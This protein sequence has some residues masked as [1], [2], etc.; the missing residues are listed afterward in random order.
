MMEL[1]RRAGNFVRRLHR[2]V[3]LIASTQGRLKKP[4]FATVLMAHT[5]QSQLVRG[6][7]IRG[8]LTRPSGWARIASR[9]GI[10]SREADR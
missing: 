9:I 3:P 8:G 7:A 1:A 2:L 6:I 10:P 5:A 4:V